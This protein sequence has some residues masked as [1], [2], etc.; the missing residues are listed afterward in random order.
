MTKPLFDVFRS[1]MMNSAAGSR[2]EAQDAFI[3]QMKSDPEYVELLARDYFDRMAAVWTVR[4]ET[5]ASKVFTRTDVS[6]DKVERMSHPRGQ[7]KPLELVRRTREETAARTATAFE[8]MKAKVR[9]IV[10]LDLVLPDG[11]ALRDATGSECAKAGG[12]FP[13]WPRLSSLL[14]LWTKT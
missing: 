7:V 8:E 13:R 6:Q 4:T 5:Q 10:L 3:E 12:F 9:S 1:T 2:K 11:K 14:R